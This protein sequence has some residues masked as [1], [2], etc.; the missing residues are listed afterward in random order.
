MEKKTW[1]TLAIIFMLIS[2]ILSSVITWAVV[3][4]NK[5][6][7]NDNYCYYDVCDVDNLESPAYDYYYDEVEGI[8]SCFDE[9]YEVYEQTYLG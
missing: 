9:N 1:K 6:I 5:T 3:S 2:L 4:A 7:E 8:C